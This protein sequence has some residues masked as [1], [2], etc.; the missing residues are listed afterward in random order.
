MRKWLNISVFFTIYLVISVFLIPEYGVGWDDEFMRDNAVRN[1]EWALDFLKGNYENK[2]EVFRGNIDEHGP[3]F[4]FILLAIEEIFNPETKLSQVLLR[5]YASFGFFAFMSLFFY[6]TLR[7]CNLSKPLS[8]IGWSLLVMYPRIFAHSIFNTK[9]PILMVV[10]VLLLYLVLKAQKEH[11]IRWYVLFGILFGIAIDIRIIAGI[12]AIPFF[13]FAILL[14]RQSIIDKLKK[15]S[16]SVG[17]TIGSMIIFWP[18]LWDSPLLLLFDQFNVITEVKQLNMTLFNGEFYMPGKAPWYYLPVILVITIPIPV[19]LLFITGLIKLGKLK[20]LR[21]LDPINQS[22]LASS[23]II[24]FIT[25]LASMVLSPVFYNGW[26]HFQFL[27]PFILTIALF[28]IQ[29]VNGKNTK[30]VPLEISGFLFILLISLNLTLHPFGHIYFSGFGWGYDK[31]ERNYECDYWGL[32]FYQA[33]QFLTKSVDG[34]EKVSVFVSDKPGKYNYELL[35]GSDR[36]KFIIVNNIE[37]ADYFITNYNHFMTFNT[38]LWHQLYFGEQSIFS[39]PIFERGVLN[40]RSI[41][42]YKL[43]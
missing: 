23:F 16:V 4:Q 24:V 33:W 31:L 40:S 36:E 25:L 22:L 27:W 30:R 3:A 6:K 28:G 12:M 10:F 42:I 41:A 8:L 1:L 19:T 13:I 39:D 17:I 29:I 18:F 43:K 9:D 21:K 37:S 35:P 2:A 38:P 32:G 26:R 14:T 15:L 20:D 5:H 7:L 11:S 34:D